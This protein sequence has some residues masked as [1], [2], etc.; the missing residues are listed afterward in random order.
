MNNQSKQKMKYDLKPL[1]KSSKRKSLKELTDKTISSRDKYLEEHLNS[2][3]KHETINFFIEI[4][5]KFSNVYGVFLFLIEIII[6]G[7]VKFWEIGF[8]SGKLLIQ[9]QKIFSINNF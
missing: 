4:A 6:L 3:K 5:W 2:L 1:I 7:W 8:P 9:K